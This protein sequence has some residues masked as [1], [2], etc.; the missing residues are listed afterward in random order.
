MSYESVD[1]SNT[2]IP[3]GYSEATNKIQ[4]N[5]DDLIILNRT[6]LPSQNTDQGLIFEATI[7]LNFTFNSYQDASNSYM[8]PIYVALTGRSSAPY[9][10]IQITGVNESESE[11]NFTIY[12]TQVE[13]PA[14]FSSSNN[15]LIRSYVIKS[16]NTSCNSMR[17]RI[18]N[19]RE[20]DSLT[21]GNIFKLDGYNIEEINITDLNYTYDITETANDVI[22]RIQTILPDPTIFN[23]TYIVP[24]VDKVLNPTLAD[25][26]WNENHIY[27][28]YTIP[29]IDF[30]NTK[31]K[32]NPSTIIQ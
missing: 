17:I 13:S 26:Y 24:E 8:I 23:W 31:I 11:V 25:S 22:K 27:N 3:E 14:N 29:K 6:T 10:T 1:I 20:N 2:T 30:S 18:A 15:S 7:D 4:R 12:G 28:K 32:I 16:P 9:P 19:F 5:S 21:I